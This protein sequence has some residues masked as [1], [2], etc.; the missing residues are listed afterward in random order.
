M[1]F[2]DMSDDEDDD[3]GNDANST[4]ASRAAAKRAAQKAAKAHQLQNSTTQ[5]VVI[6]TDANTGRL[7]F[8]FGESSAMARAKAQLA[9]VRNSLGGAVGDGSITTAPAPGN[10][11]N[12][13]LASR[14]AEEKKAE[15]ERKRKLQKQAKHLEEMAAQEAARHGLMEQ[16]QRAAEALRSDVHA[17]D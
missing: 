11:R 3:L 1:G 10:K 9:K 8:D 14:L 13:F 4:A 17:K 2:G 15:D 7:T 16:Q 12:S 5:S 6:G